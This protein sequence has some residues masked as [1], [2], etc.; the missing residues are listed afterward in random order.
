MWAPCAA[1][2]DFQL[3]DGQ[4]VSL[5]REQHNDEWAARLAPG[6]VEHGTSYRLVVSTP[7]G[8]RLPRRDPYARAADYET[9]WCHADH[10]G[11]LWTNH[12]WTPRPFDE[13]QIYELHIGSFT[14]EGTFAAAAAR[15]GHVAGLGF[16]AVQVMPITEH[17]DRWG[18]NP[19]QLMAVHGAYGEPD[20]FRAF[21]D[22][23]HGLGMGVI[24]DVVLHHGA[25]DG[26]ELWDWD[27]WEAMGNGGIYH[28]GSGD[29]EWGRGFAFWKREVRDMAL[30]ACAVWLRDFHCDGLRFDSANDLPADVVQGLTFGLRERFPGRILTAEVTPENPQAVHELGF[31]SLWV[32]SGYFDIIQ[33]HRALGRGHHGGGDWAEGWNLPRLRTVMG[34][35]YGFTAPTQC[36]KYLLGSHDQCGCTHGGN[37][38]NYRMVGGRHRYATDQYGGGREDGGAAAAARLWYATNVGAAGLTMMFMGTEWN[39]TGWWDVT[40]ERRL[41][42]ALS[43]DDRG[44]EMMALVRDANHLRRRFPALRK[45]WA[46]I[47][48]EDRPNGV[49]VFERVGEG[50]GRVV[51]LVNAGRRS[52]QAGEY[53]AWIG[54]GQLREVLCTQDARYGGGDGWVSNG[55]RLIEAQDGT[56]WVNVPGQ[57]AMVFVD[58]FGLEQEASATPDGWVL[59]G[60]VAGPPGMA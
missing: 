3:L 35:H 43:E 21:V 13:I 51:V 53:G 40:E 10:P 24:V 2:I 20:D 15:L 22:A 30:E 37:H 6:A 49:L 46:N 14:P 56:M 55:G 7:D 33:Q 11:Y 17:S 16:T 39:Q 50:M 4:Q 47:L 26:N 29:T 34:L 36:V 1:G 18:Y 25:V 48:H 54:G 31:D 38:E 32:H 41:Q 8:R 44:A 60:E 57:C 59:G 58:P 23:A 45:G 42:W 28:E 19:R 9:K 52:W 5:W 27:G 12:D